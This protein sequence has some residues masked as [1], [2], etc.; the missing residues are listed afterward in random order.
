M[1]T[2]IHLITLWVI[3]LGFC[4]LVP[5]L[6][7]YLL[8]TGA[9]SWAWTEAKILH[10]YLGL[11][12]PTVLLKQLLFH[13]L[14]HVCPGTEHHLWCSGVWH[15]LD[16]TLDF[17]QDCGPST[18]IPNWSNYLPMKAVTVFTMSFSQERFPSPKKHT[19]W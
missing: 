2:V 5:G 8:I 14:L 12:F 1:V 15:I 13:M 17:W 11:V 3:F 18:E 10:I 7:R 19:D 16:H 9:S 6:W 4:L